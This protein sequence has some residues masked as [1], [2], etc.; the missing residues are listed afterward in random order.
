MARPAPAVPAEVPRDDVAEAGIVA[1]PLART[2]DAETW[3]RV[4][5]AVAPADFYH[6]TLRAIFAAEVELHHQGQPVD[7]VTLAEQMRAAGS[8]GLLAAYNGEAY[9]VA[10]AAGAAPGAPVVHYAQ[11]VRR[12]AERREQ[13]RIGELVLQRLRQGLEAEQLPAQLAASRERE[14]R[15]GVIVRLARPAWDCADLIGERP[16]EQIPS[17]LE[18]LNAALGGGYLTHSLV[19]VNGPTKHGKSSL[20]LQ[21]AR[22]RAEAGDPV[23]VV[24][25]EAR[26]R[27]ILSRL[28]S[29]RL[30]P[31]WNWLHLHL[32][33]QDP[34]AEQ[35]RRQ[36]L[37]GLR[38][39]EVLE[40]RPGLTV[41]AIFD[42]VRRLADQ[43]GRRPFVV[44]D[45]LQRI[46]SRTDDGRR[47]PRMAQGILSD[48]LAETTR[49][50]G[51]CFFVLSAIPRLH[52]S[53]KIRGHE[54][55]DD[56]LT[57][58]A[59]EGGGVEYDAAAVLFLRKGRMLAAPDRRSRAALKVTGQRFGAHN[60][61]PIRLLF[62]GAHN[63][64]VPDD[65][66]DA[67]VDPVPAAV[68]A[69]LAKPVH[70][71]GLSITELV[72][73]V[74][75]RDAVVRQ[76]VREMARRGELWHSHPGKN[77]GV[78]RHPDHAPTG[79]QQEMPT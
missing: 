3:A 67:T 18:P 23:L 61:E 22:F 12:L 19:V 60:G 59:K 2:C 34:Q 55:S 50:L 79:E 44:L 71:S 75:H 53:E 41:R 78:Y 15:V 20:A 70:H 17:A 52:Y 39:L 77:R 63:T 33:A 66:E 73:K 35:L 7:V 68:L 36:G 47:D 24:S 64:F 4:V 76:V 21:E 14:L 10:L 74:D 6:P 11:Q 16:P 51:A 1:A 56:E 42:E 57:G 32:W 49:D 54:A 30:Q 13:I 25:V 29:Q 46:L 38:T 48:Q 72:K 9:F 45:Y 65:T 8:L 43:S 27:E 58:A 40:F 37:A 31:S 28:C 5:G 26:R 62:D 69:V